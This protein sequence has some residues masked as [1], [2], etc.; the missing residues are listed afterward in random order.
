MITRSLIASV[1][2]F[3]LF[4]SISSYSSASDNKGTENYF[5]RVVFIDKG[6]ISTADFSPGELLSPAALSRR[7]KA[8][9]EVPVFTDL[10]V[11][12]QY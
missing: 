10:P 9:A 8:G 11:N 12:K 7:E 1:L 3:L 6:N 5:Y 2:C 4:F